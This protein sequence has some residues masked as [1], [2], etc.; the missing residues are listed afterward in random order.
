MRLASRTCLSGWAAAD[1]SALL[2]QFGSVE[3]GSEKMDMFHGPWVHLK[4]GCAQPLTFPVP[5]RS[6]VHEAGAQ[7]T[8]RLRCRRTGSPAS[9]SSGITSAGYAERA[10]NTRKLSTVAT[11]I[12]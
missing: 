3:D 9:S 12:S 1:R 11:A 8:D 4:I 2:H 6:T 10:S 7:F 5:Q